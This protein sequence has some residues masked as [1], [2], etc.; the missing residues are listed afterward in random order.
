MTE[1]IFSNDAVV[2][3]ILMSTIAFIVI[4]SNSKNP[5]W[6]KFYTYVPTLFLCYFIP[7]ILNSVGVISGENSRLYF[8]A[9]R[10]LLPTSLV[11]L[12]ISVDLPAIKKLGYKAIVMFLT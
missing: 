7:S 5:F 10:Y 11:L 9:S 4:S 3:G 8:V 12:T 1:P 6:E 2:L